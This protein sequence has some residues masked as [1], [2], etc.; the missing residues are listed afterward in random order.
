MFLRHAEMFNFAEVITENTC[1]MFK[2]EHNFTNTSTLF[3][4]I[5]SKG[6]IL[7]LH[8]SVLYRGK[9]C[10]LNVF[11][12]FGVC[13]KSKKVSFVDVKFGLWYKQ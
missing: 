1:Y 4:S 11:Y 6:G 2:N 10:I 9:L 12:I 13:Q 8:H 7:Q 3:I 5:L